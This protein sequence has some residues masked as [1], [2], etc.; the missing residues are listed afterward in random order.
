MAGVVNINDVLDGHVSL[1]V[2]CVD[3]LYLNAYVPILQVGGQVKRFLELHLGNPIAS[4]VIIE[5][6]GNRFRR[7]VKTF[8]AANQVPVLALKEPD[9]SRRDDRKLDH[10]RPICRRANGMAGFGVVAIVTAQEFRW[11]FSATKRTSAG[12]EPG[13]CA[14]GTHAP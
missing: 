12:G 3:R 7:D 14:S 10:V 5:R 13:P 9:R 8:A 6:I 2:E 11:V 1:E 4:P